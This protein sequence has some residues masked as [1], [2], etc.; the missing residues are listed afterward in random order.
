[1]KKTGVGVLYGTVQFAWS[2]VRLEDNRLAW[3]RF[4]HR[5]TPLCGLI[6]LFD[7]R[8]VEYT[9]RIPFCSPALSR[10]ISVALIWSQRSMKLLAIR[11]FVGW[12]VLVEM[13][14][15]AVG[16]WFDWH[17][18]LGG[19]RVGGQTL[20]LPGQFLLWHSKLHPAD[21]WILNYAATLCLSLLVGVGMVG[22]TKWQAMSKRGDASRIV[23]SREV[24]Q[25]FR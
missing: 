18:A 25:R 14:T 11:M 9:D 1:M 17:P 24:R 16:W 22:V 13:V 12:L 10:R 19:I 23:S 5:L 6:P 2:P 8:P 21:V 3:L 20:Y 7:G 4:V 15:L